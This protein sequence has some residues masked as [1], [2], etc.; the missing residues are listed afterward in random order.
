MLNFSKIIFNL[1]NS[2]L[3]FINK[4][5]DKFIEIPTKGQDPS[6]SAF[7]AT[8]DNEIVINESEEENVKNV[9]NM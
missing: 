7:G 9:K 3:Y 8:I 6:V 4:F 5:I 2:A 1:I